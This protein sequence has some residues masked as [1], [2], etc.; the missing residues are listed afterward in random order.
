VKASEWVSSIIEGKQA[1]MSS[2]NSRGAC[3]AGIAGEQE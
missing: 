3:L 2:R 1:S